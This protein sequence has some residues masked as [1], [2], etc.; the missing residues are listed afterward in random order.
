[1]NIK[2]LTKTVSSVFLLGASV[3]TT[4]CQKDFDGV[5]TL[6]T[7]SFVDDGT[8][9]A[10]QGTH[11]TWANGDQ[12]RINSDVYTVTVN[13]SNQ[14]SISG[15][16]GADNFYAVYPGS[17]CG[18][19]T[20]STAT[21][22]LPATYQY[23]TLGG[24]QILELPMAGY[25]DPNSDHPYL[26]LNH[27]TGA[28]VVRVF[29]YTSDPMS[30]DTVSVISNSYK[31]SGE[32]TVDVTNPSSTSLTASNESDKK[33]TILFDREKPSIAADGYVDVM[34]PVPPVESAN[35]FTIYVASHTRKNRFSHTRTSSKSGN[36]NRNQ[37]GYAEVNMRASNPFVTTSD[38]L[39]KNGYGN[40]QIKSADNYLFIVE[41]CNEGWRDKNG[42][43]YS[44]AS[45][46]V[47]NNIDMAGYVV[48]SI[49]SFTGS[50]NGD[51]KTISNLTIETNY[52]NTQ[53]RVG[54]ISTSTSS[55]AV[56][57]LNLTNVSLTYTGSNNTVYMGGLI[58][59]YAATATVTG[60][61]VTGLTANVANYSSQT[62][63]V[64][65]LM[66]ATANSTTFNNCAASNVTWAPGAGSQKTVKLRYAGLVGHA[67]TDINFQSCNYSSP[68]ALNIWGTGWV[69]WGGLVSYSSGNITANSC[70]VTSNVGY[71]RGTHKC[72]GGIVGQCTN[73]PIID[74]DWT[75]IGGSVDIYGGSSNVH[76][77]N[78]VG[79]GAYSSITGDYTGG[80]TVNVH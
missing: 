56:R 62:V 2:K 25:L 72:A 46:V 73:S 13:G 6:M 34:V 30:I 71:L 10:V 51:N 61:N 70:N 22:N 58:G 48:E 65:G 23:R 50:I 43:L 39:D 40:Y 69:I 54:M 49:H 37:V 41:A 38:P 1:M 67:R 77:G 78:V 32:R 16:P 53:G 66:G 57:N 29:N 75:T 27:V 26:M 36:L 12:V 17:L 15:V 79:D 55:T 42:D 11:S 44:G 14:A 28:I 64:A 18:N 4:G 74:L 47:E 21:L 59:Y 60:C 5:I 7:E 35:R 19:L 76:Y 20:S 45:Y 80:I 9:L 31:L 8:K 52:T 63:Y 33:V 3:L 68:E 24:K